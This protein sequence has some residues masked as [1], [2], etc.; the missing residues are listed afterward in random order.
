MKTK[1]MVSKYNFVQRRH[2]IHDLGLSP[3]IRLPF[4]W[5]ENCP[6]RITTE[7][8]DEIPCNEDTYAPLRKGYWDSDNNAGDNVDTSDT[9]GIF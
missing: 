5:G 2:T 8:G 9:G 1:N 7:D 6:E 3:I 4:N